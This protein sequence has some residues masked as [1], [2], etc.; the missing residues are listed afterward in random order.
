MMRFSFLGTGGAFGYPQP[1][2]LCDDCQKARQEGGKNIRKRSAALINNDL[3]ID[4]GPDVLIS[5]QMHGLPLTEVRYCLLTH[6]HPDHL[7][8][9]HLMG[10]SLSIGLSELPPLQL[11]ATKATL[12]R[13]D[14]TFL[15]DLA[16]YR[17]LDASTQEELHLEV[18]EIETFQPFDVGPYRVTAFPANHARNTSAVLYAI[19]HGLVSVFYGTDTDALLEETWQGM[20]KAGIQFDLVVLD[21][22]HGVNPPGFGHMNAH[23]VEQHTQRMRAEGLL[24]QEGEVYITHISH[25]GNPTH[26][27][28]EALSG[29]KGYQVAYDGLT[30]SLWE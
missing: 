6:P 12:E 22:T 26:E 25:I 5:A 17:L 24:K 1:F 14:E 29:G 9:T 8:L 4:I 30:L 13:A 21:N 11:Y 27:A 23:L 28:L 18:H 20:H 10:R 16:G 15:R 2:C 7:D 3:L 19:E